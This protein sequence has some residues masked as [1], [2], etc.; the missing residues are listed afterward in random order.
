MAAVVARAVVGLG[1]V[2]GEEFV[3]TKV[4]DRLTLGMALEVVFAAGVVVVLTGA[5]LLLMVALAPALG[6]GA[7]SA[8]A[9]GGGTAPGEAVVGSEGG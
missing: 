8:A 2:L 9:V 7:S 4:V 6:G 5:G 3:M 1:L